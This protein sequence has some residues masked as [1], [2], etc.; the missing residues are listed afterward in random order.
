MQRSGHKA[1]RFR[2]GES[3]C[4][5]PPR[6]IMPALLACLL[7]GAVFS[8]EAAPFQPLTLHSRSGQFIVAGVPMQPMADPASVLLGG[9]VVSARSY[10]I[11]T[12]SVTF[13]RL[14]PALVAVSCEEIKQALLKELG[15]SD[16]WKGTVSVGI[17]PV[18]Q[19]NEPIFIT[20]V[21]YA[22]GWSYQ[23]AMADQVDRARFISAIVQV[24]IR[25]IANRE[26]GGIEAELPP[27]L[28]EGLAEHLEA[29]SLA[30]LTFEL[31]TGISKKQRHSDPLVSVREFLQNNKP[32]TVDELDWPAENPSSER[33]AAYQNCAHLLVHELLR[34]RGG[35][36]RLL[37][38]VQ[39][40]HN[41]LNWQTAF[42]R[43]FGAQ[44]PRLV[45]F[46]KWWTL[47]VVQLA[48]GDV[49]SIFKPEEQWR[50]IEDALAV[51]ASAQQNPNELPAT[52]RMTLQRII[53]E[54]PFRDQRSLLWQKFHLLRSLELRASPQPAQLMEE[55]R[56]TLENYLQSRERGKRT[57]SRNA[58]GSAN[59]PLLVKETLRRLDDLDARREQMKRLSATPALSPGSNLQ[60]ENSSL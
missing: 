60:S 19:D 4:L 34:L 27:W 12:S 37:Q 20:S 58:D 24:I 42:F 35:R 41:H 3:A 33:E 10:A 43:T 9:V 18:Q 49:F 1:E 6:L 54:W 53:K 22:N 51:R 14:D 59:I 44:F 50:Q 28:A 21:H 17:H 23:V 56:A 30:G 11:S 36:S 40:A 25:E 45:D 32:L 39:D 8:F 52:T 26:A 5:R 31:Q 46:D 13:V 16:Q 48:H 15:A 55:Y 2:E 47:R 7:C 57:L 29:T 38:M